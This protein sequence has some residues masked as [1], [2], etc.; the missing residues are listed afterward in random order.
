MEPR[1]TVRAVEIV[2][3]MTISATLAQPAQRGT[4]DQLPLIVK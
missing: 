4:I 1:L 3:E 2:A